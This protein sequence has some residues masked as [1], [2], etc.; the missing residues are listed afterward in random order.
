MKIFGLEDVLRLTRGIKFL[1]GAVARGK[2]LFRGLNLVGGCQGTDENALG[3][4]NLGFYRSLDGARR[5]RGRDMFKLLAENA[6]IDGQL[7]RDFK[8]EFVAHDP[9]G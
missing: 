2:V 6:G 9:A 1:F 3:V 4:S 7:L 8:R 5:A